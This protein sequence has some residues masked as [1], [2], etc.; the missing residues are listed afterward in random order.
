MPLQSVARRLKKMGRIFLC[1]KCGHEWEEVPHSRN[2]PRILD[3]DD[4]CSYCGSNDVA[5]KV[6]GTTYT[7][8]AIEEIVR[9][10]AHLNKATESIEPIRKAI[11]DVEKAQAALWSFFDELA[12]DTDFGQVVSNDIFF[13]VKTEDEIKTVVNAATR[14]IEEW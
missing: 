1:K 10:V 2:I 4:C 13:S 6:V 9:V 11:D 5:P 7:I 12:N 3:E 14:H 8:D